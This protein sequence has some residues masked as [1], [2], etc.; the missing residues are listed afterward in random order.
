MLGLKAR[1][2]RWDMQ[3]NIIQR[4]KISSLCQRR[5]EPETMA[6]NYTEVDL[7]SNIW[8]HFLNSQ[9]GVYKWDKVSQE[10]H[11][12]LFF[13]T[14]PLEL[15][16]PACERQHRKGAQSR[17]RSN[18]QPK[19]HPCM[20]WLFEY[21]TFH[22]HTDLHTASL[23]HILGEKG[24]KNHAQHREKN[25]KTHF[26]FSSAPSQSAKNGRRFRDWEEC[27]IG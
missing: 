6:F 1:R 21:V 9:A 3:K 13:L 23:T 16:N 19:H 5:T 24:G 17:S 22:N 26:P 8:K 2:L 14:R 18:S 10:G 11:G 15:Q 25:T 4:R 12:F 7:V 27:N 20:H